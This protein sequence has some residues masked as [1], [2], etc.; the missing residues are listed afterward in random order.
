VAETPAQLVVT[1]VL[2]LFLYPVFHLWS[3]NFVS[4]QKHVVAGFLFAYL[5]A[6]V[7]LDRLWASRRPVAV[8]VLAV[9]PV[10]GGLQCYWQDRSWSDIRPLARHLIDGMQRGD[11]VVAESSWS[12]TVYLY[13][14]GMIDS[15]AAVIDANNAPARDRQDICTIPWLVGNSESAE[16]VRGAAA[17][18]PHQRVH[19]LVTWEYYFDTNRLWV[20][21]HPTATALYRLP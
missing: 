20:T 17:R 21:V 8:V 6:G 19:S 3:A 1:C 13:P 9:L 10:W 11:R 16:L 14:M 18:C 4:S 5:L 7:A 2:A 12:Y 15:P